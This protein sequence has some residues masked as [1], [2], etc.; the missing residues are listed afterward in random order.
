MLNRTMDK[1][2]EYTPAKPDDA[3]FQHGKNDGSPYIRIAG[4]FDQC[5]SYGFIYVFHCA[6]SSMDIA[7]YAPSCR[8]K[9]PRI[10]TCSIKMT[11]LTSTRSSA[12]NSIDNAQP[13]VISLGV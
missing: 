1:A 2:D 10:S 11:R 5:I 9:M 6:S 3:Y 13:A 12:G 7:T 4:V 8:S